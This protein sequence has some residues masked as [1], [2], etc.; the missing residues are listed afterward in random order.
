[1]K[2]MKI[3]PI[4]TMQI[5]WINEHHDTDRDR[6]PNFSDCNPWN[7]HEQGLIH[8]KIKSG[9]TK[10][11]DKVTNHNSNEYQTS[12]KAPNVKKNL[13]YFYVLMKDDNRYGGSRWVSVGAEE[14]TD[15]NQLYQLIGLMQQD[16][17]VLDIKISPKP[18][19][20]NNMQRTKN[21]KTYVEKRNWKENV[22]EG[23]KTYAR[24]EAENKKRT[25]QSMGHIVFHQP[26]EFKSNYR[27]FF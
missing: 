22:Q 23:V 17:R 12:K 5:K 11:K 21:V 27:R 14:V 1:M 19:N 3:V 8:D 4:K 10:I 26:S 13:T 24:R 25:Y 18:L 15:E 7:P 16:P 20:V 6:I 9:V 2:Q